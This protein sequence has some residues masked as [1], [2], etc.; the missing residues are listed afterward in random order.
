[1]ALSESEELELMELEALETSSSAPAPFQPVMPADIPPAPPKPPGS[2]WGG[3]GQA[4]L[5]GAADFVPV[6][7]PATV[8]GL[9]GSTINTVTEMVTGEPTNMA[10][11]GFA[12]V[13]EITDLLKRNK[14]VAMGGITG[15]F[16][17]DQRPISDIADDMRYR[18]QG[19]AE[20]LAEIGG[21]GAGAGLLSSGVLTS[22]AQ[23]A[24][25]PM[26]QAGAN[27]IDDILVKPFRK[28]VG[29]ATSF[30]TS[31]AAGGAAGGAGLP[32]AE[33]P[34]TDGDEN[35]PGNQ[36][37]TLA[38]MIG[39]GPA[40]LLGSIMGSIT[41]PAGVTG[42]K[43]TVS[44]LDRGVVTPG[45][46]AAAKTFGAKGNIVPPTGTI[47][48]IQGAAQSVLRKQPQEVTQGVQNVGQTTPGQRD[49]AEYFLENEQ[50]VDELLGQVDNLNSALRRSGVL[51]EGDRGL[52]PTIGETL[53][54]P[55]FLTDERDIMGSLSQ[56]G[57]LRAQA[58]KN[59]TLLDQGV[60]AEGAKFDDPNADPVTFG[61]RVQERLTPEVQTERAAIEAPAAKMQQ[62]LEQGVE[63][64]RGQA[65]PV[66][67]AGIAARGAL[68][69]AEDDVARQVSESFES[70]KQKGLGDVTTDTPNFRATLEQQAQQ[71][72]ESNVPSLTEKS[73]GSAKQSLQRLETD[74]GPK[75]SSLETV[76]SDL[77]RL[78][79]AVRQANAS[80]EPGV[81][82]RNYGEQID[83]LSKDFDLAADQAVAK[84]EA[85]G[86]TS[87]LEDVRKGRELRRKQAVIFEGKNP[88]ANVL[89]A[90]DN[91]GNYTIADEKIIPAL[92]KGNKKDVEQYLDIIE[93][94]Q[95]G[96]QREMS[97]QGLADLYVKQVA[98][99]GKV[100]VPRHN[101]FMEEYG[102]AGARLWGDKWKGVSG[103]GKLQTE[104]TA[105]S[106]SRDE[107]LKVFNKQL[108]TRISGNADS[109]SIMPEEVYASLASGN[110]SKRLATVQ[111]Y[112][113]ATARTHPDLWKEFVSLRKD[114]LLGEMRG[115]DA[116]VQKTTGSKELPLSP[117]K[118]DA[119]LNDKTRRT[120]ME[121]LFGPDMPKAL[122]EL[123][124][125]IRIFRRRALTV[126]ESLGSKTSQR[127]SD[128]M[129]IFTGV[130]TREGRA[131]T[132]AKNELQ[133]AA[134]RAEAK[135]VEDPYLI[136]RVAQLLKQRDISDSKPNL[137]LLA[138]LGGLEFF[139][140]QDNQKN[141]TLEPEKG[142][143]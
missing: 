14:D 42:A 34:L 69:T 36:N 95:F 11:T 99:D 24:A 92:L 75:Q 96:A 41:G 32:Q 74:E 58:A 108:K 138:Q 109:G 73:L 29:R 53:N 27:M 56:G 127:V 68:E 5:Q 46:N 102:V 20:E 83:A 48:Q 6:T 22:M 98:P 89:R 80:T 63:A 129:R 76:Q 136:R 86:D 124:E 15:F 100:N 40:S 13:P 111:A 33:V 84:A 120:E 91:N 140:E 139:A 52:V 45:V 61:S 114:D 101:K 82:P 118:I 135:M 130:L 26:A 21:G 17:G 8:L 121:A 51:P 49:I 133:L 126:R 16:T 55:A 9:P 71:A 30:E 44:A 93:E 77:S 12:G 4:F 57:P 19:F 81:D 3:A 38:D 79:R 131:V 103:L 119:I 132:A 67:E 94:P 78:K 25:P 31:A 143:Q 1:M 125:G 123:S 137:R 18:P 85:T 113:L 59:E 115:A 70:A 54:N 10:Q 105:L 88:I 106:R 43:R 35:T 62:N 112:K 104:A 23:K 128:V 2:S 116:R 60:Q 50:Q 122:E 47:P 87:L 97:R 66:S 107:A 134:R 141:D 28:N 39:Q 64:V 142:D 90:K 110:S 117:D 65:V 72:Q 37:Q 7:L